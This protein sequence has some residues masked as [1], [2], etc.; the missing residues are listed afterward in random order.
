MIPLESTMEYQMPRFSTIQHGII[1]LQIR[2]IKGHL[3]PYTTER[4]YLD[5]MAFK[6]ATQYSGDPTRE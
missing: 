6:V 5:Y 2:A 4:P 1:S 3:S